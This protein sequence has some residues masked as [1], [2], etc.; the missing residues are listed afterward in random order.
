MRLRVVLVKVKGKDGNKVIET[1]AFL[2][3]GS[4]VTL[5]DEELVRELEIDGIER[6][7]SLTTQEKQNSSRKGFEVQLV[8]E[9][10]GGAVHWTYK[11]YGP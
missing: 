2:D 3:S 10:L 1:Y 11:G 7:L 9:A 4:D 6:N 8:V 5:R